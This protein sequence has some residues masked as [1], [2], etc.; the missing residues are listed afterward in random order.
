[1]TPEEPLSA[2]LNRP[3]G[4]EEIRAALVEMSNASR[5]MLRVNENATS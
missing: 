4:D 5:G 3:L 2:N 1:M